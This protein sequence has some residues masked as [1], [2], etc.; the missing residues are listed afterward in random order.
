MAFEEEFQ[1]VRVKAD[2]KVKA[3]KTTERDV[4]E[5]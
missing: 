5:R 2:F 4:N 1:L 3:E